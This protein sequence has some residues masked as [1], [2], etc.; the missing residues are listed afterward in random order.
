MLQAGFKNPRSVNLSIMEMTSQCSKR[1]WNQ[2]RSFIAKFWSMIKILQWKLFHPKVRPFRFQIKANYLSDVNYATDN[3]SLT[4]NPSLVWRR[5]IR[6]LWAF[7]SSSITE[8]KSDLM[9]SKKRTGTKRK[10]DLILFYLE[11]YF[12]FLAKQVSCLPAWRFCQCHE[13]QIQRATFLTRARAARLVRGL[14]CARSRVR[15]PVTSH[16]CF[17]SSPFCAALTRLNYP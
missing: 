9:E 10:T 14:R 7:S 15:S 3:Q 2:S 13:G 12:S 8:Y 6:P 4:D 1:K 17:N 5:P 16:P 11:I